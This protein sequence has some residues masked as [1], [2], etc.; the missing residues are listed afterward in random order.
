MQN[1]FG[2]TELF[3]WNDEMFNKYQLDHRRK[4][5]LDFITLLSV[6]QWIVTLENNR[7]LYF[8]DDAFSNKYMFYSFV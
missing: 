5:M 4:P 2:N 3:E 1:Y 6:H 8:S 7:I